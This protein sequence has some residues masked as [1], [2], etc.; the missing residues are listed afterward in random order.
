MRYEDKM[1]GP[2]LGKNNNNNLSLLKPF[3]TYL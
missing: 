3:Q 2:Q 1:K